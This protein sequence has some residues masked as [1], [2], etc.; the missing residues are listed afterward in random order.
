MTSILTMRRYSSAGA[1]IIGHRTT[2]SKHWAFQTPA[3]LSSILQKTDLAWNTATPRKPRVVE[4][5]EKFYVNDATDDMATRQQLTSVDSGGTAKAVTADLGAGLEAFKPYCVEVYNNVM[6]AS[7]QQS[8]G[9]KEPAILWHSFLGTSPDANIASGAAGQSWNNLAFNFIGAKG[10]AIRAMKSG[11]NGMLIAK[12]N[13]L[14]LLSGFGQAV[15]GWQ[16]AVTTLDSTEGLGCSW[17]G[18]LEFAEG[19]WY[20]IGPAGPFVTDGQ[21]TEV[22]VNPRR[23]SWLNVGGLDSASVHFNPD[24]RCI[25]FGI[26]NSGDTSIRTIWLWHIDRHYWVGDWS[27]PQ[28][29]NDFYSLPAGAFQGPSAAPVSIAMTHASSTLTSVTGVVTLGDASA[30][31]EIWVDAGAGFYLD[32]TLAPAATAFTTTTALASTLHLQVK[33]RHTKNGIA[34]SFCTQVDAYT[35]LAVPNAVAPG[36]P[37]HFDFIKVT[38]TQNADMRRFTLKR[39]LTTLN[40][41]Y[42]GSTAIATGTYVYEDDGLACGGAYDYTAFSTDPTWPAAIQNSAV[43]TVSTGHTDCSAPQ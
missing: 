23:R 25:E 18:G 17:P 15:E 42:D 5:F 43:S 31:T 30:S 13:Q 28:G 36:S 35:L 1:A 34:S 3:D 8:G 40:S 4:M 22:I 39:G 29:A 11:I 19:N 7:G 6:F 38:L 41:P 26:L 37:F 33:A 24:R 27:L 14:Y 10:E 2:S 16:Y 9:T 12:E 32:Q 20:G 21:N